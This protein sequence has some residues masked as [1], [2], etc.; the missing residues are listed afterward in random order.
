[1]GMIIGIVS[2]KGGVGKSTLARALGREAA[3]NEMRV[4][5][6]DLDVQQ[7]TSME[8]YRRRLDRNLKP[9]LEVRYHKRAI[10]AIDDASDF[11]LVII[12]GPARTSEGTADIARAAHFVVQPTG[13]SLDDLLPA[14]GVFHD[15]VTHAKTPTAKLAF[16]LCRVGTQAEENAARNYLRTAGYEVLDGCIYERPSYR[17]AQNLGHSITETKYSQLNSRADKLIQN[18]VD[19]IPERIEEGSGG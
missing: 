6:A 3:A 8:W 18:L 13:A 5:I 11:D 1:M 19:R 7:G 16:A 2:Q 12:D 10:E 15:L 14:V 17:Q 4:L 9:S